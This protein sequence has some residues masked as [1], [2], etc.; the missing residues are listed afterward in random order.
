MQALPDGVSLP[1][2]RALT[3]LAELGSFSLAADRLGLSQPSVSHLVKRLEDRVGLTLVVRGRPVTLTAEGSSLAD[4]ARRAIDALDAAVHD[5]QSRASL[6]SGHLTLTVGNL[7]AATVLPEI[8]SAFQQR[9]PQLALTVIDCTVDQLKRRLQAHEAELGIGALAEPEDADLATALLWEGP[10]DV[11]CRHDHPFAGRKSVDLASLQAHDCVMLNAR[12]QP[13]VLLARQLETLGIRL[14]VAHQVLLLST[15]MGLLRAGMGYALLP[16]LAAAQLPRE[17]CRLPLRPASLR[18]RI[19]A[20]RLANRP[21]TPAARAFLDV[22][23]AVAGTGQ[24]DAALAPA[25]RR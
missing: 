18:W 11:F 6:A 3:A 8:L 21:L 23:R 24:L 12:S 25:Q 9:Y 15:A 13:W 17:L 5:C 4:V 16:R 14:Q 20:I 2:L 10:V 1:Q 7:S 19:A 22:A